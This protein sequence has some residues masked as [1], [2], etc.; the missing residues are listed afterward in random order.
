M[1]ALFNGVNLLDHLGVWRCAVYATDLRLHLQPI[2]DVHV[3]TLLQCLN[4]GRTETDAWFHAFGAPMPFVLSDHLEIRR[5]M[6]P[7]SKHVAKLLTSWFSNYQALRSKPFTMSNILA[8]RL[9]AFAVTV[10]VLQVQQL[11][12]LGGP[13]AEHV[14]RLLVDQHVDLPVSA[15]LT[16]LVMLTANM[17]QRPVLLFP[18]AGSLTSPPASWSNVPVIQTVDTETGLP[19]LSSS[20]SYAVVCHTVGTTEATIRTVSERG[21]SMR[22]AVELLPAET[23]VWITQ[24]SSAPSARQQLVVGC[25]EHVGLFP[26]DG[27]TI[28][29]T[30]RD[31]LPTSNHCEKIQQYVVWQR[32]NK[33]FAIHLE[34]TCVLED[35]E[36]VHELCVQHVQSNVAA[37]RNVVYS[38]GV[39]LFMLPPE[40]QQIIVA[41]HRI[42][43]DTVDVFTKQGDWWRVHVPTLSAHVVGLD[44]Y[45]STIVDACFYC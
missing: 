13:T 16:C 9:Q 18:V 23:P 8:Q 34:N 19:L 17:Q 6:V 36:E 25:K 30:R 21:E 27:S 38:A 43:P 22:S 10:P 41:V 44:I 26:M 35:A 32:S 14:Q 42:S 37:C 29:W 24:F 3:P 4:E 11:V 45:P 31:I 15:A 28:T 20:T 33:L 5:S 12:S 7:K 40:S 2:Q 1:S 39:A